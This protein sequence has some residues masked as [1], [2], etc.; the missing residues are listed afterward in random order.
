VILSFAGFATLVLNIAIL[1][2]VIAVTLKSEGKVGNQ[3]R[4]SNEDWKIQ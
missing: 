3:N 1:L 4:N 2:I